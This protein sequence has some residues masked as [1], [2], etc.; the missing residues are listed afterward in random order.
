MKQLPALCFVILLLF[1]NVSEAQKRKPVKPTSEM[2]N[3]SDQKTV[4]A[5]F[6]EFIT[7]HIA[8][9]KTNRRE[10]VLKFGGGWAKRFIEAEADYNIDIQT[11]TSLVSP[12]VGVCEFS[13]KEH[14]SMFHPNKNDALQDDKPATSTSTKHKHTYAYQDGKWVIK[15]R[16]HYSD[17]SDKWLDCNEV[18]PEGENKGQSNIFGCWEL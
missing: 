16:L 14:L 5:S 3:P 7:K 12:Y 6:K 1:V 13:L 10:R 8:S 15:T 4:V 9:Y 18:I 11:T 17:V 2:D